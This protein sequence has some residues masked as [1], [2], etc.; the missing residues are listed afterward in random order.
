[1]FCF[2]ILQLLQCYI[3]IKVLENLEKMY[4][5]L[6]SHFSCVRLCS[7]PKTAAHQAPLSLGFSRQEHWSGLPCP[8][9]MHESES[10]SEGTQSCPTL[11]DPMD[12]SPPGSSV[13]GMFQ[14]RVLEWGGRKAQL[15]L[16]SRDTLVFPKTSQVGQWLRIFLQSRRHWFNPWVGK[17]PQGRKWQPT[18]IFLPGKS[19]GQRSLLG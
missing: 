8:S 5:L 11:S 18:P 1:M 9:P 14:A 6:L 16:L 3:I 7:T 4:L 2:A 17:I 19:H 12:C 15:F 10:E 13:Y